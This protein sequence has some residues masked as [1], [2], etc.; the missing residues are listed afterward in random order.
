MRNVPQQEITLKSIHWGV[1]GPSPL[2]SFGDIPGMSYVHLRGLLANHVHT[3]LISDNLLQE[4]RDWVKFQLFG[5]P[6]NNVLYCEAVKAEIIGMGHLC[7]LLYCDRCDVICQLCATVVW[8]ELKQR[9]DK[10]EPALEQGAKTE[11]FIKNWSIDHNAPL[12]THLGMHDGPPLKFLIGVFIATSTSKQQVLF[13]QEAIKADSAHMLFG[14]YTLFF[15]YANSANGTMALLGFAIL[16]RNEDTANW[17][18]FWKFIK[19]IHPIMNQP[20]KTVIT[21]QDKGSLASIRQIVPEAGLFHCA[22]HCQQNIKKKFGGGEREYATH[23][24]MD[25]QHP[26]EL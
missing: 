26:H 21:D 6:D 1:V 2:L 22:F 18:K 3:E 17:I 14:K 19:S 4:A 12:T 5:N 13:L 24:P 11:D 8:E 23:V 9:E 20:T 25:V 15:V 10:N 16:F 7:E